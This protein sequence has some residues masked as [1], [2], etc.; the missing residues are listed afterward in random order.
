MQDIITIFYEMKPREMLVFVAENLNNLPPLSMNNFDMSHILEEI[1][2]IKC[3]MALLQEAQEKSLAVHVAMCNDPDRAQP[4]AETPTAG[5]QS[6]TNPVH[7]WRMLDLNRKSLTQLQDLLPLCLI[8][9][10]V[11]LNMAW[12]AMMKTY[13]T[14]P[15]SR[16]ECHLLNVPLALLPQSTSL[17]RDNHNL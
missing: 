8:L 14:W 13:C 5:A 1:A 3:K 17:H 6:A 2:V 16:M 10:V 4:T 12:M 11:Q 15:V 7:N 9:L